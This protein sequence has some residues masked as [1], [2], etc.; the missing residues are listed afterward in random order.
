MKWPKFAFVKKKKILFG[1]ILGSF[2]V[3][4]LHDFI[5]LVVSNLFERMKANPIMVKFKEMI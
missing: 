5:F 4:I 1:G 2:H 3:F